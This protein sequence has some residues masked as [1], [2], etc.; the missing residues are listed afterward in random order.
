MVL[1]TATLACAAALAAAGPTLAQLLQAPELPGSPAPRAAS[2]SEAGL[3]EGRHVSIA[4][5]RLVLPLLATA[6]TSAHGRLSTVLEI[7]N[8]SDAEARYTARLLG[9]GGGSPLS[10]LVETTNLGLFPVSTLQETLPAHAGQRLVFSPR[11]SQPRDPLRIVWAEFTAAPPGALSV[12]VV[13]RAEASDGTASRAAIPP[14]PLYRRAWL[15][16]DNAAGSATTVILVNPGAGQ[17]ALTLSFRYRE[18]SDASATCEASDV[19][20][21]QGGQA[22][23]E[24]ASLLPCSSGTLG[25]L[26]ISGPSEFT[27]IGLV[28]GASGGILARELA[29]QAPEPYPA[30]P[31]WAVAPGQVGFGSPLA[32]G[33]VT[34]AGTPVGG[35]VYTV[36]SSKWQRRADAGDA[37]TDVP[38]T[39]RSGQLCPYEPDEPGEYRAVAEITVGDERR[40]FTSSDV[41]TVGDGSAPLPEPIPG[42][43][44]FTNGLG[45]Q[46]VK[47]PAG[48]FSMG[49]TGAWG[50]NNELPVTQ[51]RISEA[52]WM[53]KHE[54]TQGQWQ[55]VMGSNPATFANCGADCPV[56]QVS[57]HDAQEFV[58]RLNEM[59]GE[60]RYRL[61][62]EAEWEY[63]ARAGTETDTYAGNLTMLGRYDAP[64]LDGIAWYGGNSGVDYEGGWDCSGF[65]G[66]KQYPSSLCGP[67]PV[68]RKASNRFALHDMLGNLWEWV[69]DWGG[70]YP[71][72]SVTDPAGPESGTGRVARGGGWSS[73]AISNT[74][75][76]RA[77]VPPDFG[78]RIQGFRL[79]R[80]DSLDATT[81][82]SSQ[83]IA[84]LDQSAFTEF[85]L[86]KRIVTDIPSYYVDFTAAGRFRETQGPNVW[87]GSYTYVNT[88]TN[89]GTLTFNY[90]DGDRCTY[91]LTFAS[92][93]AGTVSF[94]CNDGSS[95]SA[96]WRL[97]DATTG[98]SSQQIAPLD[99]SAFTE[100]VLNKRIVTD[101]PSYYVDFTA[102]GRFRETQG[103]NVWPGS[104]TY[105]NTGTNTG[106]LTFNYDDGDRCTYSLTFASQ[107]A[108]TVSFSC[109]DGSSGSANWRLTDIP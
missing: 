84:P 89:T 38:G 21:P 37:W 98:G 97:V 6:A 77:R 106:T 13:L 101:I 10:L 70:D 46:F 86:N 33:C 1:P 49:A 100:F 47:I 3:P 73:S 61:P 24:T 87:P 19:L 48:E 56:E 76:R 18:F 32:G 55:A 51:V 52:F 88:G 16:V 2:R 67:H 92:Q 43:E 66:K 8:V 68:G 64:L 25:L 103:P 42:L 50:D 99:Q 5:P 39:A 22:A 107:T 9:G 20:F 35:T 96:N 53:G 80:K 23:W 12:A 85:V 78:N 15:H 27:G 91:S 108:G 63:A 72:G 11:E 31:Q 7:A 90:D 4:S 29:G 57:W 95:G 105:V 65:P 40:T 58:A 75:A 94:S 62:T 60:A 36:H 69:Q 79:V 102:A 17:D 14:A 93:T 34:L 45:M 44:E 81:G 109:N 26:E 54:V 83:Q 30:L 104:Y 41:L 59:E 28:S 71:G 82:G 74:S